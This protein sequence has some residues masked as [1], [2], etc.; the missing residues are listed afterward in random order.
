MERSDLLRRR[1]LLKSLG[2]AGLLAA[3]GLLLPGVGRRTSAAEAGPEAA[4]Q[5]A[6]APAPGVAD[7]GV[8]DPG[9]AGVEDR[10][11]AIRITGLQPHNIGSQIYLKME[12]N[13]GV[14][15]WGE[16][17]QVDTTVAAAL[18]MSMFE[19]LKGENPT[20]ID[21][22]W[23][24]IY[25]AHRDIRGGAFMLHTLAGIDMALWDI[26][27][28]LWSVPVYRLLGGQTRD[29]IRTY[30]SAKALK[31]AP[32]GPFPFSG[33][34]QQIEGILDRIREARERVGPDGDV[35]FDAH[36]AL[37]PATLIQVAAAIEPYDVLF[38]EEPW[39]P[40][41]EVC[42]KIRN[43]VRA[44]LATGERDRTIWQVLPYLKEGVIDVL[45]ADV[46][47]T[48]GITPMRKMA[49]LAEA[50]QVPLAPHIAQSH[51]GLT[52]S[53]HVVASIP[54]FLIHEVVGGTPTEII[55]K[56]WEMDAEGNASLP[57]GV[58][59][60]VDVDE[61]ALA[62]AVANPRP[63]SNWPGQR[64]RDGSIADY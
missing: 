39:V 43:A 9:V 22:L 24:K 36:S 28:K 62:Q 21:H 41:M 23:Q 40:D 17:K 30:P 32:G 38:I 29:K 5:L 54:L 52:A 27:G 56:R 6:G 14:S 33:T 47:H 50:Y 61:K 26:A 20:R 53:F 44:P 25:R 11:S 13:F 51:L 55:H 8:A 1:E 10:A 42:R 45:Q 48:G 57:E 60:C 59:L 2:S 46:G 12:T 37:P 31:V 34:P 15:G 64:L 63:K 18:A 7:P 16:I 35:M 49:A 3:G 19:M 58:G 4:G